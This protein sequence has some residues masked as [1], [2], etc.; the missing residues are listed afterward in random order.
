MHGVVFENF[1]IYLEETS[2][3]DGKHSDSHLHLSISTSG[4][5]IL[6]AEALKPPPP[7]P[8]KSQRRRK[9]IRKMIGGIKKRSNNRRE[10]MHRQIG[11]MEA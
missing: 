10:T 4:V 6:P 1:V 3:E 5:A 9:E 7:S 8:P 11:Q 2:N